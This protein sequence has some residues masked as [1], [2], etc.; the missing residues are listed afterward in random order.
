M[1]TAVP[2][3]PWFLPI[4][5]S[6]GQAP[7]PQTARVPEPVASAPTPATSSSAVAPAPPAVP[8]LA[9]VP[10]P[11]PDGVAPAFPPVV[12]VPPPDLG[13]EFQAVVVQL[14]DPTTNFNA[15]G[16]L[17]KLLGDQRGNVHLVRY[18]AASE[19]PNAVIEAIGTFFL[20][21]ESPAM[22]PTVAPLLGH[23]DT[24]VRIEAVVQVGRGP[25]GDARIP[26]LLRRAARDPDCQVRVSALSALRRWPEVPILPELRAG[27]D[28]A[29]PV[30]QAQALEWIGQPGTPPVPEDV[31]AK[32]RSLATGAP[33]HWVRCHALMAYGR[34]R[35]PDAEKVVA[36]ALPV[37][38]TT[39]IGFSIPNGSGSALSG[40][41]ATMAQCAAHALASLRGD[42]G[43]SSEPA[44]V[45]AIWAEAAKKRLVSP[46]PGSFCLSNDPCG[47]DRV[48]VGYACKA[49]AALVDAHW[50]HVA[51]KAC[52]KTAENPP[53][54]NAATDY[55]YESGFGL[56]G[57]HG[58][59]RVRDFVME[60][61]GAGYV[62]KEREVTSQPCK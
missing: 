17:R 11:G 19:W 59:S 41:Y 43:F 29:C 27:L 8:P 54:W 61:D 12:P 49:P 47:S 40:S 53:W 6:C 33:A 50:R 39:G 56:T 25:L 58:F 48:C 28:D 45:K 22:V 34:L 46:P 24:R 31:V 16:P 51:M 21:S 3:V 5:L 18:F 35:A 7:P 32:V 37:A 9:E 60:R 62:K 2:W 20:D 26:A 52:R 57:W 30:H 38:V 1:K 14:A 4:V 36:E 15:I 44:N 55:E 42:P 23:T 13:E 10:P